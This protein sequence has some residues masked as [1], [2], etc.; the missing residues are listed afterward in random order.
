MGFII[1]EMFAF[2][3]IDEDGDEGLL[4][5]KMGDSWYPLVGSNMARVE[6]LKPIAKNIAKIVGEKVRLK[7]FK[8]VEES[9][10]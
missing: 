7:K 5:T 10:V 9:E 4:G 6:L 1:T 8:F 3:A 2:V